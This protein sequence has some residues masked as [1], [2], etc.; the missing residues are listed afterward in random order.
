MLKA[1]AFVW[2]TVEDDMTTSST[3]SKAMTRAKARL[4]MGWRILGGWLRV[5]CPKTRDVACPYFMG[6]YSGRQMG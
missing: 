4:N 6:H 3:A 2:A 1:F 5:K